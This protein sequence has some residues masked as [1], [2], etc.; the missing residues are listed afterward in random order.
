MGLPEL[1]TRFEETPV[2]ICGFPET[3]RASDAVP[4]SPCYSSF[5]EDHS[6]S[7]L[8][9]P[10]SPLSAA[11]REA[12]RKALVSK[13]PGL[14]SLNIGKSR[15]FAH[16]G[17]RKS[18]SMQQLALLA[19][20]QETQPLN[21]RSGSCS[22]L[23]PKSVS[24]SGSNPISIPTPRWVAACIALVSI[25]GLCLFSMHT[26]RLQRLLPLSVIAVL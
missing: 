23:H 22:V 26:P 5:S 11:L 7:R 24:P 2:R 25:S 12:Q 13:P 17:M 9:V 20:E 6:P 1:K 8:K 14:R 4:A 3:S 18:S 21:M 10:A 16:N 19:E 15:A